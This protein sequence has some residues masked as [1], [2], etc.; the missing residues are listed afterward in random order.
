MFTLPLQRSQSTSLGKGLWKNSAAPHWWSC[1]AGL[2][3]LTPL[4]IR[5][6]L[7]RDVDVPDLV[8]RITLHNLAGVPGSFLQLMLLMFTTD[9]CLVI[10]QNSYSNS[11]PSCQTMVRWQRLNERMFMDC[12]Y[13]FYLLCLYFSFAFMKVQSCNVSEPVA[14]FPSSQQSLCLD[15]NIICLCPFSYSESSE[16]RYFSAKSSEKSNFQVACRSKGT[17]ESHL[18]FSVFGRN[19]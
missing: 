7:K 15:K 9:V 10:G 12:I 2:L 11:Y 6:S 5:T 4:L 17:F 8:D 18:R 3:R 1:R 13:V 14:L 19:V 16:C